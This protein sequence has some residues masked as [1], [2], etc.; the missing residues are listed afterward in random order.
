MAIIQNLFRIRIAEQARPDDQFLA[1]F[2]GQVVELLPEDSVW[3]RLIRIESAPGAA[4]RLCFGF[5]SRIPNPN[6]SGKK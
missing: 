6:L 4:R 1:L 5:F 3:D 2:S